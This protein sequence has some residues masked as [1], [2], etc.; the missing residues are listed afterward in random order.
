MDDWEPSTLRELF[1]S[2]TVIIFDNRAVGNTTAGP[3][4]FS[5]QQIA[6]DTSGLL[7]SL[8]QKTDVLGFYGFIRSS[9][10]YCYASRKG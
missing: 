7:D 2:H 5:I 1:S 10:A 8:K 6:N 9:T 4:P 3:K